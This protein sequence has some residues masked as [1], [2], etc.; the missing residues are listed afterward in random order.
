MHK[1]QYVKVDKGIGNIDKMLGDIYFSIQKP[2]QTLEQIKNKLVKNSETLLLS[3]NLFIENSFIEL[4]EKEAVLQFV[5]DEN[6]EDN[7]LIL[8]GRAGN[9]KTALLSELQQILKNEKSIYLSIKSD[10]F[11]I[12]SKESLSNNFEIDDLHEAIVKISKKEQVVIL[13]D[14]LDALSLTLSS[15]R[16]PINI[17][18]E[19]IQSL[20]G[21]ENVNIVVSIREYDLKN[22]PLLK[23]I[24]DT[25]KITMDL[26]SEEIVKG[27][28]NVIIKKHGA[29]PKTLLELLRTPLHLSLFLELNFE[30]ASHTTIKTLQDLYQIF[31]KQKILDKTVDKDLQKSTI[32]LIDK[33]IVEMD[34]SKK[35]EVPRLYFEDDYPDAIY[36][37]KSNHILLEQD[38]KFTFFHQTFYDY[39]FAKEFVK[40]RKS[41]F[42]YISNSDQSIEIRE[43]IKQIVEFLRATKPEKYLS[44]LGEILY[45]E[46][47]RFH[48]KLLIISYLGNIDNPSEDEFTFLHQLFEEEE[49]FLEYFLESWISIGWLKYFYQA[50]YFT[51]EYLETYNLKYRPEV[52]INKD[53]DLA[54]EILEQYPQIESRNEAITVALARLEFWNSR[55]FELFLKNHQNLKEDKRVNHWYENILKK[56]INYDINFVIEKVFENIFSEIDNI[57]DFDRKELFEHDLYNIF[58]K[59]LEKEPIKVIEYSLKAINKIIIKTQYETRKEYLIDDA[60]FGESSMWQFDFGLYNIWRFYKKILDRLSLIAEKDHASFLTILQPYKNSQYINLLAFSIFGYSTNPHKYKNEI[61]QL[62]TNEKI[63]EEI[64]ESF[65]IGYKLTKLLKVSFLLFDDEEKKHIISTITKINPKWEWKHFWKKC[66]GNLRGYK[67]YIYFLQLPVDDISRFGYLKVF[68]ELQRK[69]HDY[70]ERVPHKSNASFVGTPIDKEVYEKMNLETWKQSMTVFDKKK[71][72]EKSRDIMRGGMSQHSRQFQDEV[73]N[74]PVRFYSFLFEIR[75]DVSADYLSSGLNGLIEVNYSNEK[76]IELIKCYMD[77]D[78]R[79]LQQSIIRAIE[80]LMQKNAFNPV[81]ID[82]FENYKDIEYEGFKRDKELQS[83]HDHMSTSINS[84]R[85]VLAEAL[86]YMFKYVYDDFKNKERVIQLLKEVIADENDYVKFGLLR[87]IGQISKLDTTLYLSFIINLIEQDKSGQITLYI[88]EHLNYLV[89]NAFITYEDFFEYLSI[90]INYIS[91][92]EDD[93]KSDASDCGEYLGMLLFFNYTKKQTSVIYDLLNH[94]IE[95][96]ENIIKGIVSQAFSS[97]IVSGDETRV[98]LAKEY[99]LKFKDDE[100]VEWHYQYSLEKLHNLKLIENDFKFVTELTK[101]ISIQKDSSHFWEYLKHE[102]YQNF[103]LSDKILDIIQTFLSSDNSDA[104]VHYYRDTEL[105]AFILELYSRA[106]IE[107]KKVRCLDLM[108]QFLMS[109]KYR[110][111]TKELLEE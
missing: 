10:S 18:L 100:S 55:A 90:A 65:D 35:I 86:P 61:F 48:I 58:K 15:N 107:S 94:G 51:K 72:R 101:S 81:F 96:N 13:I 85:G 111:S 82:I 75:D 104:D 4:P 87:T 76:V 66:S 78:D 99:I 41:L 53:T 56:L 27:K 47:I 21:S 24:N 34:S 23:K 12:T 9:G 109:D 84:M 73:K 77:V 95:T 60:A 67:Q 37:L 14:Q 16:E 45:S 5:K 59:I 49:K 32:E 2:T 80:K 11:T 39:I 30:D 29:L 103:R 71:T 43:R 70:K 83:I 102:Y 25:N 50:G 92:L 62:F 69:F 17:I 57:E 42:E 97:E 6:S 93:N 54:L 91:S 28:L 8:T 79:H 52:F 20:K 36:F 22:D 46:N 38:N 68:Q 89:I 98:N 3:R 44:Q 74:S 31:W 88:L 7:I 108:D 26:L 64:Q 19:F 63:L 110:N 1:H 40:S 106:K 33:I 105:I